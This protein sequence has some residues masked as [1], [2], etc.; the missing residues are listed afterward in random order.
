M[1]ID[2]FVPDEMIA[3]HETCTWQNEGGHLSRHLF[4]RKEQS[5]SASD[6]SDGRNGH[7]GFVINFGLRRR[8]IP[9]RSFDDVEHV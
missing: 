9:L 1:T 5:F 7:N 6:E 4:L 8:K 2:D 3:F